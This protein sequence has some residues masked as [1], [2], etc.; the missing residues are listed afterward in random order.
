MLQVLI[1]PQTA[2]C[3]IPSVKS[4][5][6]LTS[7]ILLAPTPLLSLSLKTCSTNNSNKPP[8]YLGPAKREHKGNTMS[9]RNN[10]RLSEQ[11]VGHKSLYFLRKR[12]QS[13][14]SAAAWQGNCC[15]FTALSAINDMLFSGHPC[16]FTPAKDL[17]LFV[18]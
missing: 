18:P 12:T 4:S 9:V 8:T 17:T 2:S 13:F 6:V 1:L 7:Y 11:T 15:I 3:V 14:S 5:S 10:T 16:L